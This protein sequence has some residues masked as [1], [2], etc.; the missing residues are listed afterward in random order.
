MFLSCRLFYYN[1]GEDKASWKPPRGIKN[2]Q[3]VAKKDKEEN[4]VT[5]AVPHG[6]TEHQDLV[7]GATYFVVRLDDVFIFKMTF[8][9]FET[10]L[11]FDS[12]C[13]RR[14]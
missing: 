1:R 7:S 5:M 14:A 2:G 13:C 9:Y 6:Y 4:E 12:E 10:E 8:L 3:V 11:N